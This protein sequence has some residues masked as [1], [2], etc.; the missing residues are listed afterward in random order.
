MA[1]NIGDKYFC[2]VTKKE[3]EVESIGK[4]LCLR[5]AFAVVLAEHITLDR[6]KLDAFRAKADW[7]DEKLTDVGK[8][9]ANVEAISD[10]Q[11]RNLDARYN[12]VVKLRDWTNKAVATMATYRSSFSIAKGS[13]ILFLKDWKACWRVSLK[14]WGKMLRRRY[15]D[16]GSSWIN[17]LKGQEVFCKSI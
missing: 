4:L 11:S 6:A 8:I 5:M 17:G 12:E 1:K 3:E 10:K 7:L 14:W 16:Q 15:R 13:W 2:R 9:E